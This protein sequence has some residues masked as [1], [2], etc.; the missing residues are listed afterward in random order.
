MINR[1]IVHHFYCLLL[2]NLIIFDLENNKKYITDIDGDDER[3]KE[4][5]NIIHNG[6]KLNDREVAEKSTNKFYSN[7]KKEEYNFLYA[8]KK[9]YISAHFCSE[10]RKYI[11]FY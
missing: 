3:V 6:N 9:G 8:I 4:L 1:Y 7:F 10:T 11:A 5:L 2:I